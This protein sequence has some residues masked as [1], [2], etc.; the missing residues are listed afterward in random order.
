MT[1]PPASQKLKFYNT[2]YTLWIILTQE[3]Q[4]G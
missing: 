2:V 3:Q 4:E 1:N